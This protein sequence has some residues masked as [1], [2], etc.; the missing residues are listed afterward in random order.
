MCIQLL[1]CWEIK[2]CLTL[3]WRGGG[4]K[5]RCQ[6]RNAI[7]GVAWIR[8]A[9]N[10][11]RRQEFWPCRICTC[12]PY[13]CT[14]VVPQYYVLS[15]VSP[16]ITFCLL[17]L[18]LDSIWRHSRQ[19]E[20]GNIAVCFT[21]CKAQGPRLGVGVCQGVCLSIFCVADF[22]LLCDQWAWSVWW[23]RSMCSEAEPM[24]RWMS[25]S[26]TPLTTCL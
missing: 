22:Q 8:W 4:Q 5:C 16:V 26:L 18:L 9:S 6:S 14:T 12:V 20:W 7:S 15:S 23:A 3:H 1:S 11:G 25:T 21:R 10:R 13:S 24:T 19:M 17:I 2:F